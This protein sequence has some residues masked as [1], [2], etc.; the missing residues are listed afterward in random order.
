MINQALYDEKFIYRT[1]SRLMQIWMMQRSVHISLITIQMII[2]LLSLKFP[3]MRR[4]V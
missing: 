4:N 1:M 3:K 2:K